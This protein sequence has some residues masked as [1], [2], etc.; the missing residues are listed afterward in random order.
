VLAQGSK[1]QDINH[2][3][4][5]QTCLSK[6]DEESLSF[7]LLGISF[8][9]FI[10]SFP[11]RADS[12]PVTRSARQFLTVHCFYPVPSAITIVSALR[13]QKQRMDGCYAAASHI[14]VSDLIPSWRRTKQQSESHKDWFIH[15]V[16]ILI[17]DVTHLYDAER[18]RNMFMN[19][20][21]CSRFHCTYYPG[22]RLNAMIDLRRY[23]Q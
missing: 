21:G 16:D 13:S 3:H 5:G 6:Q 7:H 10:T 2:W 18:D 23:V 4:T 11:A 17:D 15:R 8:S 12:P 9:L 20:V 1:P 14:F 19:G 22:I